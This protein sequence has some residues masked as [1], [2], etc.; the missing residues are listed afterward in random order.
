M[1]ILSQNRET[2]TRTGTCGV[3]WCDLLA[4]E[5]FGG[6]HRADLPAV[7]AKL[8]ANPRTQ[9][10]MSLVWDPI[11]MPQ[12][13]VSI[14]GATGERLAEATLSVA[15]VRQ[16][17]DQLAAAVAVLTAAAAVAELTAAGAGR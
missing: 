10:A 7:D 15:E 13:G 17:I 6:E 5:H 11:E 8:S 4:E 12:A 16:L 9:V 14:A 3:P 2:T 1:T